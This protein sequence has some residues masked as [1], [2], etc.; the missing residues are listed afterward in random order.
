MRGKE[1]HNAGDGAVHR[2]TPAC[3]GKRCRTFRAVR[4]SWD[5]PRMCGEKAALPPGVLAPPGS[6][7]RMR[8]KEL[9][10]GVIRQ[11]GGITPAHAGKSEESQMMHYL[12]RDHPRTCGEKIDETTNTNEATGSPPHMRGK[13]VVVVVGPVETG[14][15]PAHAGKSASAALSPASPRDHPR[16]CGEKAFLEQTR[17]AGLGS[18]P[19]MRGKVRYSSPMPFDMRIT[20]AHAG[21]SCAI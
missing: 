12:L 13:V 19:H 18:P 5:H 7:P 6:P 8:G 16:T 1:A 14:I 3:A 2:I 20:P 15:T 9:A 17:Q 10:V 21:K 11:H 4:S